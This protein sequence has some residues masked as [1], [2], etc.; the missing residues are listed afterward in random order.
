MTCA[1][2]DRLAAVLVVVTVLAQ[3]SGLAAPTLSQLLTAGATV[4]GC[5]CGDDC[6]CGCRCCDAPSGDNPALPSC[7]GAPA[8]R[9]RAG[10]DVPAWTGACNCGGH[11]GDVLVGRSFEPAVLAVAVRPHPDHRLPH[12]PAGAAFALAMRP[13]DPDDPVPR[14][15][16]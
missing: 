8:T 16:T 5:G 1:R 2:H 7:C 11:G 15:R 10:A 12:S 13:H 9:S 3:L 14:S 6:T 4:V